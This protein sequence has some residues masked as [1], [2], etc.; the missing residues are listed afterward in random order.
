MAKLRGFEIRG[1]CLIIA[2][3]DSTLKRR[4]TSALVEAVQA[5]KDI[6]ASPRRHLLSDGA[7]ARVSCWTDLELKRIL[8]KKV[9]L[10]PEAQWTMELLL[11]Y[12]HEFAPHFRVFLFKEIESDLFLMKLPEYPFSKPL[13]KEGAF[14]PAFIAQR[15]DSF[16]TMSA[17]DGSYEVSILYSIILT[18]VASIFAHSSH[19]VMLGSSRENV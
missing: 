8:E 4:Q 12:V 14:L 18:I 1:L 11:F 5:M 17:L 13:D 2:L 16:R 15:G 3:L 9:A 10:N 6:R 7:K 19:C